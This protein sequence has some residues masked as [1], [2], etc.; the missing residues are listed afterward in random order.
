MDLK[1]GQSYVHLP[2]SYS[3]I[4]QK[5]VLD[6]PATD[7]NIVNTNQLNSNLIELFNGSN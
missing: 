2:Q 4:N 3:I 1:S 7:S 5:I 6:D